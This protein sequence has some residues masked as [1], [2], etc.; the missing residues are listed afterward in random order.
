ME[1]REGSGYTVKRTARR[2]GVYP[3][4]TKTKKISLIVSGV[5]VAL[6]VLTVGTILALPSMIR[7]VAEDWLRDQG[8]EATIEIVE[9]D[10]GEGL[11]SIRNARGKNQE[12]K[13]FE[14]A[15]ISVRWLWHTLTDKRFVI[16]AVEL[17]GIRS[18]A[19]VAAD[20][21]LSVAGLAIPAG[22]AEEPVAPEGPQEPSEWRI[23]IG[24]VAIHDTR[25]CYRDAGQL[26]NP[27]T[28]L[29]HFADICAQWDRVVWSGETLLG[30]ESERPEG[31]LPL[32]VAGGLEL[33]NLRVT[34]PDESQSYLQIAA[35]DATGLKLRDLQQ[36]DLQALTGEGIALAYPLEPE[37]APQWMALAR[38]DAQD[39]ALSD[40][41]R[42]ALRNLALGDFTL[43]QHLPANQ[44][45]ALA[46]FSAL[47]LDQLAIDSLQSE[48]PI[49]LAQ[50]SLQKLQ[51][52]ERPASGDKEPPYVAQID[53][54]SLAQVAM[55]DRT[56]VELGKVTILSPQFWVARG[57]ES[58]WEVLGW[59]PGDETAGEP[60][61]PAEAEK[62][63]LRFVVGEL[64]LGQGG[65]ITLDDQGVKP[66]YR[67]AITE[68]E[69][70]IAGLDNQSPQ[71]DSP[72]KLSAAMGK[73]G[74]IDVSGSM[75][76]FS[77]RPHM[78][79]SGTI[80]GVDVGPLTGYAR[81]LVQHH[82]KQGSLDA[83]L[84][85]KIDSGM[86]DSVV[87]LELHKLQMEA[88]P[89]SEKDNEASKELGIPLNAALSLLRDQDDGIR[90]KLPIAGDVG[91]PDVSLQSIMGKVMG[92]AIKTAIVAYYS[93]FGL[94]KLAGAVLD[95]ATGL[96][97]EP[98]DFAVAA[99]QL[100]GTQQKQLAE[101]VKLLQERPQVRLS[102]CG[103][104]T[105]ADFTQL[106]PPPPPPQPTTEP[107]K[108]P[109]AE[110]ADA[111][112]SSAGAKKEAAPTV[113]AKRVPTPEQ[114]EALVALAAKRSEAVKDF[115]IAQ[116]GIEAK[117]LILCNPAPELKAEGNPQVKISI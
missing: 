111:A 53:T 15:E 113:P 72:V 28:A 4:K 16:S 97:F 12:G 108:E 75:R 62:A 25:L 58:G 70:S 5:I 68:I 47:T 96:S 102:L 77:V 20:G 59:V 38:L 103:D 87:E 89:E 2:K 109:A 57:S 46:R 100:D 14:V 36:L 31:P 27:E 63:A 71:S 45:K 6:L 76:P 74:K 8:V 114:M 49:S 21:T 64:A 40:F 88:I 43:R 1:S 66:A 9:L 90:L 94:L 93:P 86:M 61:A 11:F 48:S 79:L 30:P 13:G 44:G 29:P 82:I 55:P 7:W 110:Q 52:L 37:A 32:Q 117:R 104:M 95:L 51:A 78:V 91:S 60:A 84:D 69:L 26:A 116:G 39:L 106:Y 19:E 80:H 67:E 92:K 10:L 33:R 41:D 101:I 98:V 17:R 56:T 112:A 85:V 65:Q 34:N 24:R 42:L 81:G 50:L 23:E 35:F 115:L 22:E 83:T 99:T 18:A 54:L 107:A 105:E 73:Y 3:V